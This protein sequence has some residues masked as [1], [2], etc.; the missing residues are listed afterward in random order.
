MYS[1]KEACE[2]TGLT[3]ETLKYYCNEGL[4]PNVERDKHN[5]RIFSEENISWIKSLICIKNCGMSI[6][7]IKEYNDLYF[8]GNSTIPRR[9]EI[10]A[11]KKIELL[12]QIASLE[13]SVSYID[14]KQAYYDI[15]MRE[16]AK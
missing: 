6:K 16:S 10:L 8:E 9:K 11:N 5:F 3:Y 15:L 14:H 12:K 13:E 4:I 7:E 1:M 2:L